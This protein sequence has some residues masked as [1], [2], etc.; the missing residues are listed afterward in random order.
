MEN[1]VKLKNERIKSAT[2]F[3]D[4]DIVLNNMKENKT[5]IDAE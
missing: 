4:L 3:N 2:A 1:A 5:I